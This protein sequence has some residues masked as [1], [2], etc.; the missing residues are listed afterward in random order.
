MYSSNDIL[1]A[2][3]LLEISYTLD[4]NIINK[5]WKSK[6]LQYHPDKAETEIKKQEFHNKFIELIRARDICL[7]VINYS[8]KDSEK[9]EDLDIHNSDS[10]KVYYDQ[11]NENSEAEKEWEF[12]VADEKKYFSSVEF[13]YEATLS[14]LKI[15]FHS[16]LLSILS[17]IIGLEI[18]LI[19]LGI[20]SL[21]PD[22]P[23]FVWII[24][25]ISLIF[26]IFYEFRYLQFLDIFILKN[27][28]H[29]GYPIKF[30]VLLWIIE[31]IFF[32]FLMSIQ[33][34][35]AVYI[36]LMGNLGF[37][38]QFQRIKNKIQKIEEILER[39][40]KDNFLQ[41]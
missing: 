7:S 4:K 6:A 24:T 31:N 16:I 12:F 38:I 28:I 13:L 10:E 25:P 41:I 40:S 33:V 15:S 23:R 32:I 1:R 14:F 5:A 30:Y 21:A 11:D 18:I 36:F 22:L 8:I 2:F 39:Q 27:L 3:S 26:L 29:T 19:S 35:G 17:T 20:L 37:L 34:Y 9:W